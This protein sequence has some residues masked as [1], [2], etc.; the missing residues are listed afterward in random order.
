M[1]LTRP[2]IISAIFSLQRFLQCQLKNWRH[3]GALIRSLS[4]QTSSSIFAVGAA[5][6]RRQRATRGRPRPRLLPRWSY[7]VGESRSSG[8]PS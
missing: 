5:L 1:R 6:T 8:R 2:R 4:W 7:W 3:L